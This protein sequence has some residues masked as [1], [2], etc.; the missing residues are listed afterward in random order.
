MKQ[1][2]E[3][4]AGGFKQ[5]AVA[6]VARAGERAGDE[7]LAAGGLER[8]D[9]SG[10][11]LHDELGEAGALEE[12]EVVGAFPQR[13]HSVAQRSAAELADAAGFGAGEGEGGDASDAVAGFD[14]GG[15]AG[16]GE[17]LGPAAGGGNALADGDGVA[18]E[19]ELRLGEDGER[20]VGGDAA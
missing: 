12:G 2:V 15:L 11:V 19:D 13:Y 5:G 1:G 7:D 3:G 4:G 17:V 18:V 16:E 8:G 9:G 20:R 6:V 14:V 10:D